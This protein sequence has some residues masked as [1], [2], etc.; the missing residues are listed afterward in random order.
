MSKSIAQ[1]YLS[2]NDISELID[3]LVN[4]PG[5]RCEFPNVLLSKIK[6][7]A[8]YQL[9]L[10]MIYRKG[11]R[12]AC[13]MDNL[14]SAGYETALDN[15]LQHTYAFNPSYLDFLRGGSSGVKRMRDLPGGNH[16]AGPEIPL[17]ASDEEDI[18]FLTKGWPAKQEELL[19]LIPLDADSL[20]EICLLRSKEANGFSETEIDALSYH[21]PIIDSLVRRYWAECSEHAGKNRSDIESML[22]VFGNDALSPR[23]H[24][25]A[26]MILKGHSSMSISLNL[27]IALP[28]VKTH[29]K[30]IYAKLGI[31]TQSE[32]MALFLD[33]INKAENT[34]L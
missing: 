17:S 11:T 14:R 9:V 6:Q 13:I 25:V 4:T 23:E 8:P 24:Q 20:F 29:R 21:K 10:F 28:T 1:T 7:L 15:Y 18:G 32:L 34:P 33:G 30:N 27:D 31:A 19:V 2:P 3:A 26:R 22:D 12:P 16:V 5:Q